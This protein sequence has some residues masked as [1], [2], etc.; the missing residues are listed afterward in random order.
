MHL[1]PDLFEAA[2]DG[3]WALLPPAL[4]EPLDNVQIFIEDRYVPIPGE[5]ADTE[6]YGV[7][8]GVPLTER[9]DAE[10]GRLPDRIVLFRATFERE[11]DSWRDVVREIRT[12][13]VHEIA[14]HVGFDEEEIHRL[15]WG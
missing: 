9:G 13:L 15:G 1:A 4:L 6:L 10:I 12:T 14:H 7:Y 11:C 5:P 8:D 2:V 3:A